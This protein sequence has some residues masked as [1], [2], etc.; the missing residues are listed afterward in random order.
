MA[1]QT[2]EKS[3][4]TRVQC[5]VCGKW[6][7]KLV[8]RHLKKHG[9]TFD[10]YYAKFGRDEPVESTDPGGEVEAYLRMA[11]E[12]MV[13]HLVG[14]LVQFMAQD[15]ALS[16]AGRSAVQNILQSQDAKIRIALNMMAMAKISR[17]DFYHTKLN[18]V[19]ELL[20]SPERLLSDK[21]T[22]LQLLRS[23]KYL[24]DS[25]KDTLDYLKS[26][27]I[28]KRAALIGLFD[29]RTF[30]IF[31]GEEDV[32]IPQSA[33]EREKIRNIVAA[34][35]LPPPEALPALPE[36]SAS[37]EVIEEVDDGAPA[38]PRGHE[39]DSGEVDDPL[40]PPPECVEP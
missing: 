29:Q 34:L 8:P 13:H 3:T 26:M 30:N 10:E 35:K 38:H 23:M 1:P 12:S 6:M 4:S 11:P 39:L 16:D 24:R 15:E 28:E 27:S 20:F 2:A 7:G 37:Y 32:Q 40:G 9:M 36:V 18:E 33:Q 19:E 17:L 21:T 22:N 14:E 31:S 25:I 5:K